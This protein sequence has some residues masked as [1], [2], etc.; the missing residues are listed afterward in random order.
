MPTA[1]RRGR[2]A[3]RRSDRLHLLELFR[4][5][6]EKSDSSGGLGQAVVLVLQ[7]GDELFQVTH[8]HAETGVLRHEVCGGPLVAVE[9]AEQ[10]L[11][12]VV[13]AFRNTVDSPICGPSSRVTLQALPVN[14]GRPRIPIWSGPAP[15]R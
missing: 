2:R 3:P 6:V 4:V 9:G 8:A 7:T 1:T 15:A 12:H 10:R 11:G 14:Y 13:K 5:E